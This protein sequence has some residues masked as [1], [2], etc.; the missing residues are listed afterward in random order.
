MHG[1]KLFLAAALP[2]AALALASGLIMPSAPEA[3]A[4]APY[5]EPRQHPLWQSL[6]HHAALSSFIRSCR[7][8]RARLPEPWRAP[9]DTL[10]QSARQTSPSHAEAFFAENFCL[11]PNISGQ[12]TGYFEPVI[13]GHLR[14]E[15]RFTT[16]LR[17]AP[18][19]L[20]SLNS[21]QSQSLGG[22][23]H[24]LR[25]EGRLRP[26]PD[27]ARIEEGALAHLVTPIVY[28]DRVEAFFAHIQGSV[29]VQLSSGEVMRLGY[30][31]KNGQP[32]T[33]IGRVLVARGALRLEDVSMQSLKAWLYANEA[34]AGEVMRQNRSYVFFT[35]NRD[36]QER[37]ADPALGPN[38]A[39]GTPL[40]PLI[41]AAVDPAHHP[42]GLPL[43]VAGDFALTH[44]PFASLM[45]A[46]DVGSAIKGAGRID[47]FIGS[48]AAAGEIAGRI[49][50]PIEVSQLTP[51]FICGGR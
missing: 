26:L 48:G 28:V 11:A 35:H 19:N 34:A 22:V 27:R 45:I 40:T 8:A 42:L 2:A 25:V 7:S 21:T 37:D 13:E 23:S 20:V 30:A 18:P 10:C 41:S 51:R 49:R 5:A 12:A 29:A 33:A 43:I 9:F 50:A 14:P 3:N 4:Q 24:A 46:Q 31:G 32:Y 38:G 17:A 39:L 44:A 16:P 36:A 1:K 15:G 47:L 6:D